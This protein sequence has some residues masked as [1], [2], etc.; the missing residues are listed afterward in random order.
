MS[1][2]R[3]GAK[4]RNLERLFEREGGGHYLP[5]KRLQRIVGERALV[6]FLKA[7]DDLLISPEFV[8]LVRTGSQE[9]SDKLAKTKA[10]K[11]FFKLAGSPKE[12]AD[13]KTWLT[14]IA[15]AGRQLRDKEEEE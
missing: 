12:L 15:Q 2:C 14:S 4:E 7:V 5:E 9:S 11:K 10:W 1:E 6:Q 8:K 13:G 3:L